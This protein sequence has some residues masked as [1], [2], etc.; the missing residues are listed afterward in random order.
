MDGANGTSGAIWARA[1]DAASAC[2]RFDWTVPFSVSSSVF[3]AGDSAAASSAASAACQSRSNRFSRAMRAGDSGSGWT[4]A[5]PP[6]PP[7]A[8]SSAA[9]AAAAAEVVARERR[10]VERVARRHQAHLALPRQEQRL[11]VLRD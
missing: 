9:A 11:Q 5:P 1:S 4:A 2:F 7:A 8:R 10:A 3:A 6:A